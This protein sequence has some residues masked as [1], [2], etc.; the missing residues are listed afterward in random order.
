MT[1][2]ASSPSGRIGLVVFGSIAFGAAL[3]LFLVLAVFAGGSE[4]RITGSALVALGAGFV[5][6]AVAS[7]RTAQLQTWARTPGVATIAAGLA[8]LVLS[9][10]DH[11]LGL[12]GWIWP[13]LLFALVV[14]SFAHARRSLGHWS[15]RAFLYPSLVVLLLIAAG[16]AFETVAGAGATNQPTAGH[17]YLVDGH[18]L[19][20]SCIGDGSPTVV[21]FN[22][23]GERTESWAVV[24]RTVSASTR[25]CVFDRAGEGFSGPGPG[26]QDGHQLSLDL[27]VLLRTAG[28]PGPYVV[29]GHS[30][31][32]VYALVYAAMYP[33]DVAGVALIDSASPDQFDLPDYPRFYSM[34]RRVGGLLPSASRVGGRLFGAQSSREYSADR[35]E[36]N[37]LP[38]VFEQAKAVHSLHGKPLAVVTAGR[39]AM[40]GWSAA[41]AKLARLSMGSVRVELPGATHSS[42]LDDPVYA[43]IAGRAIVGVSERVAP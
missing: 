32:G 17:T 18:R 8:V 35:I 28:V 9:P 22:G 3:G 12:A 10:S 34:W 26:T 30:V 23:L 4:S 16:G 14:W 41:Q 15:R 42:L 1:A 31:G 13:E 24:E 43:R 7:R 21:L 6:L 39:G 37:E 40:R 29:A 38:R 25:V 11:A 27:H 19:Y 33:Q 5:A 36:F 20:L 2:S